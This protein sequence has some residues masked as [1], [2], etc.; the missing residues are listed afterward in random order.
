MRG[1]WR[2]L[3]LLLLLVCIC[4]AHPFLMRR[5]GTDQAVTSVEKHDANAVGNAI[6]SDNFERIKKR[7]TLKEAEAILGGPARDYATAAPGFTLGLRSLPGSSSWSRT[8]R[9]R[10][11]GW[12]GDEGCVIL[13]VDSTGQVYHKRFTDA[14][15]SNA[16]LIGLIQ[17]RFNRWRE[18]A[19]AAGSPIAR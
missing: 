2:L 13:L 12:R 15:R 17:W 18:R 6:N 11:Y 9:W 1:H 5:Q 14:T 3:V 7:M 4:L 8:N 16:D 10:G 19:F